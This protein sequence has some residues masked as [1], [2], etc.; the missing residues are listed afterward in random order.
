MP[1]CNEFDLDDVM[2]ITAIPVDDF[3]VSGLSIAPTIG[4][5]DFTPT[6]TNAIVIGREPA[7]TGGVLIPIKR[8]TGKVK[9]SE[10]DAVAGRS[11]SVSVSCEIDSRDSSVWNTLLLLERTPAHLYLTLR[12]K[13]KAFVAATGDS[14]H[15]AVERDGGKTSVSFKVH[16]IMGLQAI[17][18][19]SQL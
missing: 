15:C 5:N 7:T 16:N 3:D 1:N 14:Y 2:A 6:L 9:D 19:G 12:D 18:E 8:T 17:V 13:T 4:S 11:H 10:S